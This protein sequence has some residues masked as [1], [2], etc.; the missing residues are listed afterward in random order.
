[1]GLR[2]IAGIANTCVFALGSLFFSVMGTP[3]LPKVAVVGGAVLVLWI[4]VGV[5]NAFARGA[6]FT[7]LYLWA[8]EVERA[9]EVERARV[10]GPLAAALE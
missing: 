7:C 9:G 8:R 10:P 1:V 4:C 5:L 2:A 3:T 6:Y